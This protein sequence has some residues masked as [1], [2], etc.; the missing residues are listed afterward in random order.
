MATPV[1]MPTYN[2]LAQF[3]F[4][5]MEEDQ[6]CACDYCTDGRKLIERLKEYG[7]AQAKK[8]AQS[9]DAASQESEVDAGAENRGPDARPATPAA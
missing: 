2:E 9:P 3:V 5:F 6:G 7:Y 1:E 4:N 8:S